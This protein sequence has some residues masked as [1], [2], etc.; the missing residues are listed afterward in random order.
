HGDPDVLDDAGPPDVRDGESLVSLQEERGRN[1]PPLPQV[2]GRLAVAPFGG[3]AA[4]ALLA[5]PVFGADGAGFRVVDLQQMAE[6]TGQGGDGRHCHGGRTSG[7]DG[8]SDGCVLMVRPRAGG[9][10]D[11][12]R[13]LTPWPRHCIVRWSE[14]SPPPL[15]PRPP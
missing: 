1:L 6:A 14:R 4:L 12:G 2:P 15:A 5:G 8:L 9:N 10:G 13:R 7:G 11:D 3:H